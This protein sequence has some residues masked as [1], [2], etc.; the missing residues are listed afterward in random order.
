MM[1]MST[2]KKEPIIPMEYWLMSEF[3]MNEWV[4][5]WKSKFGSS[6]AKWF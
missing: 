5:G 2:S 6:N 4:S 1:I 3:R